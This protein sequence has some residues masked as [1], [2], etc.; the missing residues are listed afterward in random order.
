[1]Q[2]VDADPCA[3]LA[4]LDV[5]NVQSIAPVFGGRDTLL[6]RVDCGT[7]CFALRLFRAEQQETCRR[8][9][10]AMQAAGAG[11]IP[12]PTVHTAGIWQGRPA[13]LLSWCA[14]QTAAE[15]AL[16]RPRDLVALGV[17]FGRMHA[18]IHTIAAPASLGAP[19]AW[20]EALGPEE[21]PLQAHLRALSLRSA[22]LLHLDYH[23]SNV[24]TDGECISCVLDWAN[25]LPGDPRADFA[26]TVTLFRLAPIPPEMPFSR[27][28]A[29]RRLGELGWRRGYTQI[30]GPLEDMA[31]FY[32]WGGVV[33]E[34]DMAGHAARAGAAVEGFDVARTQRW[35]ARWKRRIGINVIG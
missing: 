15:T 24:M 4:A 10:A 9:V 33:M 23:A 2:S 13:L 14:G 11:G 29:L 35:T 27:T 30:A 8:E 19:D 3:I 28:M 22:A 18:R 17:L 21:S 20:I 32:A 5:A 34:R 26:R 12:V 1:M 25:A 6:W 16:A 31:A 7:G